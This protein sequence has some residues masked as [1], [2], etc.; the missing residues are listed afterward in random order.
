MGVV[1]IVGLIAGGFARSHIATSTTSTP[2]ATTA[3]MF[4]D[5]EVMKDIFAS[6]SLHLIVVQQ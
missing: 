2:I 4:F 1:L 6:T 3:R 5:M